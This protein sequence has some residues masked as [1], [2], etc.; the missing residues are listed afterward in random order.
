MTVT[1]NSN[2]H[3]TQQLQPVTSD[4]P[5][6][7]GTLWLHRTHAQVLGLSFILLNISASNEDQRLCY[8]ADTEINHLVVTALKELSTC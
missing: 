3:C 2:T 1:P 7:E 8:S 6:L 4:L 5:I